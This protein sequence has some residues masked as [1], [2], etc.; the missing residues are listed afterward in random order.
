MGLKTAL[1]ESNLGLWV[2]YS[3]GGCFLEAILVSLKMV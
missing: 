1:Q 2:V 3:K